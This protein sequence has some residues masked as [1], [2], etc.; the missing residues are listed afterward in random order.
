MVEE[1]PSRVEHVR[2]QLYFVCYIVQI[3][4]LNLTLRLLYCVF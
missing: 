1:Y 2:P 3:L 4:S